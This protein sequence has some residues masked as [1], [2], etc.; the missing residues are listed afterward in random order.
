MAKKRHYPPAVQADAPA[1]EAAAAP[2]AGTAAA[3]QG[4]SFAAPANALPVEPLPSTGTLDAVDPL[5]GLPGWGDD[6]PLRPLFD[7]PASRPRI[8]VL[9]PPVTLDAPPRWEYQRRALT[10]FDWPSAANA[11]GAEGWELVGFEPAA[12]RVHV[13]GPEGGPG[14]WHDVCHAAFKRRL[15]P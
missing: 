14:A 6:K 11:L 9:P 3:L 1:P 5:E 12:K 13:V 2:P 4:D 15:L 10:A 7:G 8:E